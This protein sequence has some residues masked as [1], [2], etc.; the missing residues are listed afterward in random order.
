MLRRVARLLGGAAGEGSLSQ[1]VRLARLW[2]PLLI[3]GVVVL[4]QLVVLPMGG[5]AFRFWAPLL[6]YGILGPLATYVT[7]N[8]IATEAALHEQAQADLARLYRELSASHE[9]LGAIQEV[10]LRYAAA[11]DLEGTIGVATRG[12]AKVT[13]AE[14]VGL[15]VGPAEFGAASGVGLT[16]ELTA[17]AQR[18]DAA[19]RLRGSGAGHGSAAL[20]GEYAQLPND[21]L[22]VLSAALSWGG[23]VEGSLHAYYRAEPS[24]GAKEAF[25]ILASQFSAVAEATNLRMRD[26]LTLMEVDRRL[27]AEGNLERLLD[28]VLTEMMTRVEAGAGGVFLLED[29][30]R[31]QLRASVGIGRTQSAPSWRVGEGIVGRVAQVM[32]PSVIERLTTA[33]RLAAGPLLKTAGSAVALPL[34]ADDRLLGVIVLSHEREAHFDR[35]AIPFLGLLASQVSL[36][37]RNATAY[38]QSEELAIVEE[39]SRIAREIHD[40]VA[41]LL[42]FSLLKLDLATRFMEKEP[43]RALQAIEQARETVRETIKEVRRSIFALRPV[44]LERHGFVETVRRYV[45]DFGQQNDIRAVVDVGDLPALSVKQEAVL[46]RIFQEAMHNVAKHAKASQVS[47]SLGTAEDGMAFVTVVDDGQGFDPDSVSDRVT[48]A[49]GLGLRQMRERVEAR[50]GRLEIVSGRERGTTISAAI[51]A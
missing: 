1:Q 51:P 8:W 14:A 19:L 46:F 49:G 20:P 21:R 16:P 42:A 38:L 45:A 26:L 23:R 40:G 24:Q 17:D 48:S 13:G 6:F 35:R 30:T 31:L 43:Q 29:E 33:E 4:Y 25:G 27:R 10:T 12:V 32:E 22:A 41:Q 36:A 5:P 47:V 39:R 11:P 18:R 50:G 3:V 9:L 37:V 7:L 28:S 15:V 2:L 34:T 44:D